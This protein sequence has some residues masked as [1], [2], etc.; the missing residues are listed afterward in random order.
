MI[1]PSLILAPTAA[2]KPAAP[3]LRR[4]P[5]RILAALPR[6][7][8]PGAGLPWDVRRLDLDRAHGE[9][10]CGFDSASPPWAEGS[11]PAERRAVNDPASGEQST[12][13]GAS[14]GRSTRSRLQ[15]ASLTTS[16][17][18]EPPALPGTSA[19]PPL[20][21]HEPLTGG[22]ETTG[23]RGDAV[24]AARAIAAAVAPL[25]ACGRVPLVAGGDHSVAAGSVV[26][27]RRGLR[28]RY[29]YDVP[30]Y[31]LW[32]DAHPDVNTPETSPSGNL[33]GMVLAGLL[34]AGPLALDT[35]LPAERVVLA[36]VRDLD[37]GER[38]F[39]AARPA[40]RRWDVAALRGGAW[41][42][43]LAALL[44]EIERRDGR[45]YVSL[46]LDVL[47][48]AYA[49]G[50]AVPVAGGA[51]PSD[52]LALLRRVTAS[53]LLAGADVVELH[54]AADRDGRTAALAA[55]ALSVLAGGAILEPSYAANGAEPSIPRT[56]LQPAFV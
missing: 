29:G 46:D 19:N 13:K 11:W 48:P 54:P 38:A 3:D 49:P 44:Q 27:V 10:G 8:A 47:D 45:L 42:P 34:G 40:I 32:L 30:L 6:H 14:G 55:R 17:G 26:G 39:L 9:E 12:L 21:D 50:V 4:G 15:P 31:L 2:G 53:G 24:A 33:H 25:A 7:Q 5:D 43:L 28:R 52:V 1:R 51:A 20:K 56:G 41:Q 35:P 36:G 23:I 18:L 37:P 22:H 16:R